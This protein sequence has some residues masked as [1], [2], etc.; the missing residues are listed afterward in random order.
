LHL[1][2]S[3]LCCIQISCFAICAIAHGTASARWLKWSDE[4]KL[5]GWRLYGWFTALSCAGSLAG[6]IAFSGRIF[7]LTGVYV[8]KN[9]PKNPTNDQLVLTM[10]ETSISFGRGLATFVVA[11]PV[12]FAF[13][14]LAQLFVLHR[15]QRFTTSKSLR[16]RAWKIAGRMFLAAVI[17]GHIVSICASIASAVEYIRSAGFYSDAAAAYAANATAAGSLFEI[18][19]KDKRAEAVRIASV[20]RF[21]EVVVL[22]V[23]VATFIVVGLNSHRI[24]STALRAL[25][26]AEKK[27][28]SIAAASGVVDS[29]GAKLVAEVQSQGRMLHRKV[30]GTFVFVLLTLLV[31]SVFTIMFAVGSSMT[32]QADKCARS[33]CDACKNVFSHMMFWMVYTPS[34]HFFCVLVSSPLALMGALWGMSGV[35]AMEQMREVDVS[36][37]RLRDRQMREI[38]VDARVPVKSGS[39]SVN[40]A[41]VSMPSHSSKA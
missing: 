27:L 14:S 18:Q 5:R 31:R 4:E 38:C 16:Q 17:T 39:S 24:I 10:Q 22:L 3:N 40:R 19:A 15:L 36:A 33:E 37:E 25:F 35:R 21:I 1:S 6:V 34:Y 30:V 7:H 23:I 8:T 13:S 20:Q 11:S 32:N 26:N 28:V 12:E 29:A 2:V 41:T 9:T